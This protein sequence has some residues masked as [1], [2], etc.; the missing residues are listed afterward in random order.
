MAHHGSRVAGEPET[1]IDG[2]TVGEDRWA[3][4]FVSEPVQPD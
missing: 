3:E 2:Y 4:G 1:R